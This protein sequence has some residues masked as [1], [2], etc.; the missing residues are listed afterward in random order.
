MRVGIQDFQRRERFDQRAQR[1][2]WGAVVSWGAGACPPAPLAW[3]SD[4]GGG[5]IAGCAH[6]RSRGFGPGRGISSGSGS[7]RRRPLDSTS[8]RRLSK[9]L[10][11]A[12][13]RGQ[14]FGAAAATTGR[15]G[16]PAAWCDSARPRY[17][18]AHQTHLDLL[19]IWPARWRQGGRS[20][21][22]EAR[23]RPR[24]ATMTSCPAYSTP[25]FLYPDSLV[26]G[27]VFRVFLGD[28]WL[29]LGTVVSS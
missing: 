5:M 23:E 18:C 8:S 2:L 17:S 11:C 3:R 26:L 4:P 15:L 9:L 14:L 25:W 28:V 29:R 13:S 1:P 19:W 12:I 21:R 27:L 16:Q 7:K 20:D 6:R 10:S 24:R 22:A